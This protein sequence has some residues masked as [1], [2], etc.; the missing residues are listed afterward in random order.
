MMLASIG[1]AGS[2]QQAQ[3]LSSVVLTRKVFGLAIVTSGYAVILAHGLAH[4]LAG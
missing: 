3:R 1:G 2:R 4:V